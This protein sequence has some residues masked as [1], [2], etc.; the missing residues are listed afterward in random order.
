M[1]QE[2]QEIVIDETQGAAQGA[3]GAT[4]IALLPK[5]IEIATAI[6]AGTG[7]VPKFTVRVAGQRVGV[8]PIPVVRENG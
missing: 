6:V 5:L 1:G 4:I 7:E 2:T 3:S 8:G